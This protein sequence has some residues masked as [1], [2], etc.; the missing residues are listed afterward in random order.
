MAPAVA[1]PPFLR[2]LEYFLT[3]YR[4]VWR[5]SIAASFVNPVLFLA[6]MGLG[7][8]SYVDRN[9]G[10]AGA[11]SL[12][13]AS[14]LA[15]LAPG[16]LAATAMQVATTESTYPIMGGFRWFRIFHGI[17]ATPVRSADLVVGWL[18]FVAVRLTVA[19]S[20]FLLV[21]TLFGA[22]DS[23]GAVLAVP[24]AVLT[25]L[26]FAAPIAAFAATRQ[27]DGAF[28]ALFRFGIMP[29]FLFSGTFF[30]VSQLPA[31]I[32]PVAYLTPLWHGVDLSRRLAL[33]GLTPARAAVHL[34]FLV[35]VAAVGTLAAARTFARRLEG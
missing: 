21:A 6:A 14:Y 30:P 11:A 8:G 34:G 16:L 28:A 19:T 12:G 2:V 32:R 31:V 29:M 10:G 7:L 1:T 4:R 9:H 3:S 24:A 26:A 15:F 23:L 27:T 13:G 22:V 20:A 25:G 5:S 35:A 33:G 17:V 18:A